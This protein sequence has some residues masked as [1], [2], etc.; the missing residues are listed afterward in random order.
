M[1][2]DLNVPF[3]FFFIKSKH[4]IK[5]FYIKATFIFSSVFTIGFC[6]AQNCVDLPEMNGTPASFESPL[7]WNIWHSTPDIISGNGIYPGTAQAN[8]TNVNGSSLAGGEM[9]FL[10]INGALGETTEGISTILSGLI[11]GNTY[12]FEVEWQQVVLD[13]NLFVNDPSGGKLS[14]YIDGNNVGVFTSSGGLDDY[15]QKATVIFT[16]TSS[17]HVIGLKGKL[18]DNAYMGAIV[19]DNF[20]CIAYLGVDIDNFDAVFDEGR[21]F[22][23]WNTISELNNDYFS[24][25]QSFDL[26]SWETVAIIDGAGNSNK[27]IHYS[28]VDDNHFNSS[29]YYRL[30]MTDF[31]GGENFSSI[32]SV[33]AKLKFDDQLVVY[34]NP[35][36]EKLVV[37]GNYLDEIEISNIYGENINYSRFNGISSNQVII[38]VSDLIPGVYFVQTSSSISTFIKN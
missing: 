28:Y 31:N 12:F 29:K 16:A 20:P 9:V 25:E 11:P 13:Y 17:Q 33:T 22:I 35:V 6:K 27:T 18:L 36:N 14:V 21:V 8:I 2:M 1:I 19:L 37:E 7:F 32:C 38:N 24:L 15:W 30:K 26:I 34:P 3:R 5:L 4:M 10:L 23:N